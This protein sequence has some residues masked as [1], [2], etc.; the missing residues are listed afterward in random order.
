[1]SS[2]NVYLNTEERVAAPHLYAVL[3]DMA[4]D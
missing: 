3:K 1:M 4:K 2:R